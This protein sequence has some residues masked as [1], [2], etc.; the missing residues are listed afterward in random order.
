MGKKLKYVWYGMDGKP[1]QEW[2]E[3]LMGYDEKKHSP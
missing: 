2:Q 3:I 1:I